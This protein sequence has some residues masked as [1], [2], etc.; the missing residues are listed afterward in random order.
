ML[1][2]ITIGVIGIYGVIYYV[3]YKGSKES[4]VP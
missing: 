2:S 3:I 4:D 1:L